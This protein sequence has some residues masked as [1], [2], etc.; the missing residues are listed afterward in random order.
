[1]GHIL[2]VDQYPQRIDAERR[3]WFRRM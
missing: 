2:V 1:M 3:L